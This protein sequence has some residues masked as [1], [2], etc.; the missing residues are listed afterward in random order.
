MSEEW[1]DELVTK[2]AV[3]D[4]L[5]DN[6]FRLTLAEEQR[7]EGHVVW[8]EDV[9]FADVLE[10]ALLAL[11]SAQ[12][13]KR[14]KKRTET[15]ARDCVSGVAAIIAA[16][17]AVDEWDGGYNMQ[18]ANMIRDAIKALPSA[19]PQRMNGK[20]ID[21]T[22]TGG[23]ELWKCSECGELELEDSYFCP[24]CGADMR[25]EQNGENS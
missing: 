23:A 3:V 18:R 9:V 22:K 11:P 15:H 21:V 8:D 1:R 4:A 17:E 5:K 20:W 19:Q 12:P 14:T 2:G 16:I 6:M 10:K 13:E 24:N 25:G 7:C